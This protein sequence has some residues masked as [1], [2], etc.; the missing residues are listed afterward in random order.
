MATASEEITID[1]VEVNTHGG[2]GAQFGGRVDVEVTYT[3]RNTGDTPAHPTSRVRVSSQIGGGVR[4]PAEDLGPLAPGE[5]VT[6]HRTIDDVLPFG[7]V[8]A[9]VTV[10]S[11]APTVTAS[12]STPVVPWLL[13]TVLLV[14]ALAATWALTR[15]RRKGR[16]SPPAPS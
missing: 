12:A 11:E 15:R 8:D 2:L 16:R 3:V 10:R 9:V 1:Q 14:V 5:S 13:L 4:S 7:S 6:V